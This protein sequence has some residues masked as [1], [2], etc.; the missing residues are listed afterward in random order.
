VPAGDP[1]FDPGKTGTQVIPLTRSNFAAGTGVTSPRQQVN[2]ITAYLDGSMIYGSDKTRADALREFSGGRLLTSDGDLL[3]F[4]AAGLPNANDAHIFPD[5]ELFL[6]GDV[7]ANENGELTSLHTLFLR[8]HNRLAANLALQHPRWGDEAVYQQARRLVIGELQA[9]T[10]NE[11]LPALLGANAMGRYS[12]YDPNANAAVA[13]EFS[14]AGFRLGHS[15]LEDEVQFIDNDGEEARDPLDL[16]DIFFNPPVI[17][18]NGIDTIMKYLASTNAE[19]IDNMVVDGVRNFLFGPPGSGGLDLASLNIQRGRD[20]GLA[21]Y[22]TTRAALGLP[23]VTSFDQI[24]SNPD[25]ADELRSL[26]K[27]DVNNIDLWVGGLAEDHVPGSSLGPTFQRIV[28][29]QFAR[30][31]A[32][33][34]YWYERDLSWADRN[35]VNATTLGDIIR[36]NTELTNLQSNVFIFDVRVRGRVFQDYNGNGRQDAGENGI[37]GVS[38]EMTDEEGNVDDVTTNRNGDYV[39]QE[40][41][42][43]DYTVAPQLRRGLKFTTAPTQTVDVTRGQIFSGVNFGVRSNNDGGPHTPDSFARDGWS[44]DGDH[45]DGHGSLVDD[46][47]R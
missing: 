19:E 2:D 8:E 14:T 10:Y 23:K 22:N 42:L 16:A 36:A 33:D 5:D 46:V 25:V 32:G 47:V 28:V 6:A 7:R 21:D 27:G 37:G 13:T 20:H 41:E 40:L 34:R 45:R 43:G 38:V 31:R 4:N 35:L 1:Q 29:N 39:F 3:P 15:M 18:E 30:T 17:Q 9:I 24:T 12:G 26:Y 44:N 11:F